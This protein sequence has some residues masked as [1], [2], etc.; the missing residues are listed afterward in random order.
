MNNARAALAGIALAVVGLLSACGSDDPSQ[1]SPVTDP[2]ADT[3]VDDTM[4][5][6]TMVDDTMVDETGST[7]P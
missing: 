5:D 3:M 2:S 6:D 1:Q 4:V 7:E